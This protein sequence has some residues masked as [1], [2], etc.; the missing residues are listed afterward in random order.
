MEKR[1]YIFPRT[2]WSLQQTDPSALTP[3]LGASPPQIQKPLLKSLLKWFTK[4]KSQWEIG[5]YPSPGRLLGSNFCGLISQIWLWELKD[6][7]MGKLNYVSLV[8]IWCA[9]AASSVA[10]KATFHTWNSYLRSLISP[11]HNS[12]RALLA[13]SVLLFTFRLCGLYST[14]ISSILFCII[15][16]KHT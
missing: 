1:Q 9:L 10:M 11:A 12:T 7:F 16:R 3:R 13:T 8:L 5:F 4:P 15:K 14:E 6:F 2:L